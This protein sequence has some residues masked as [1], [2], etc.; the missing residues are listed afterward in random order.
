MYTLTLINFKSFFVC[1]LYKFR[2]V[3]N[4]KTS[5]IISLIID[6]QG[7]F[8]VFSLN[9][10]FNKRSSSKY[11]FFLFDLQMF[12]VFIQNIKIEK[13]GKLKRKNEGN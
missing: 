12:H 8:C 13:Q 9:K 10:L 7:L 4:I 2:N 3:P 1:V 6:C 5:K 11:I